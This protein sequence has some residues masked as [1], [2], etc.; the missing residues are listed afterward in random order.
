MTDFF[1]DGSKLN[2]LSLVSVKMMVVKKA[3]YRKMMK[4]KNGN[5]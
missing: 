1:N 2:V 4:D 3:K 5:G